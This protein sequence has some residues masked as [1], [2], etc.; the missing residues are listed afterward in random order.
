MVLYMHLILHD[1]M[2]TANCLPLLTGPPLLLI[3]TACQHNHVTGGMGYL[4]PYCFTEPLHDTPSIS[5]QLSPHSLSTPV[6][7]LCTLHGAIQAI[8]VSC[9]HRPCPACTTS[10]YLLARCLQTCLVSGNLVSDDL[11]GH[12]SVPVCHRSYQKQEQDSTPM[13]KGQPAFSSFCEAHGMLHAS[14][15]PFTYET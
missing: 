5:V 3:R 14:K 2:Y 7:K 12:C 1:H 10:P 13:F 9:M 8:C 15:E 4:M 11:L 6:Q